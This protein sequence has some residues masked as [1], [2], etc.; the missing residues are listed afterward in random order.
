MGCRH[1]RVVDSPQILSL[2]WFVCLFLWLQGSRTHRTG[3]GDTAAHPDAPGSEV[4][5]RPQT[6]PVPGLCGGVIAAPRSVV[7]LHIS[8]ALTPLRCISFRISP[9]LSCLQIFSQVFF[10]FGHGFP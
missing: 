7:V 1:H 5:R 10:Y 9:G 4:L 2:E 8:V 3:G 6:H